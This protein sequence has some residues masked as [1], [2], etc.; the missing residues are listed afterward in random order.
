MWRPKNIDTDESMQN[1]NLGTLR[2]WSGGGQKQQTRGKKVNGGKKEV[3]L[4]VFFPTFYKLTDDD[5]SVL[6]ST[7]FGSWCSKPTQPDRLN[8]I[9]L[10]QQQH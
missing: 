4:L 2:V 9:N 5:M 10:V 7:F 3:K 1:S 6:V 8:V